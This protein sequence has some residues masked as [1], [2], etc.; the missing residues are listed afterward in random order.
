M[1]IGATPL[2]AKERSE[3]VRKYHILDTEYEKE[4]NDIVELAS[5]IANTPISVITILDE[6]RQ[7][8][9]AKK[10]LDIR[11]TN[12]D[13]AFC[14]HTAKG[15][16][17]FIVH[18]AAKDDR[19]S[20][21]PLVTG[22][23][24]IKF[25]AGLPVHMSDGKC[26]G[27]LAVIDTVS[28]DLT[29]AQK[30]GLNILRLQVTRLLELRALNYELLQHANEKSTLMMD[31]LDRVSD[32][33]IAVDK[34]WNVTYIN[35]HAGKITNREPKNIVG[36]NLWN[37][38][39]EAFTGDSSFPLMA[40]EAMA[41]Q[42]EQYNEEFF[43]PYKMWLE[44]HIYPSASG[45][46]IYFKDITFRKNAERALRESEMNYRR[47]IEGN[48]QPMWIFRMEDLRILEVNESAIQKYGYSRDEF[49]NL[50]ILDLRPSN[51]IEEVTRFI[52]DGDAINKGF[53]QSGPWKHRLRNGELIDVEIT[54]QEIKWQGKRARFTMA[55]DVTKRLKM[56]E[57]LR[58]AE[59]QYRSIF[60]NAV[61]GIYQTT[62]DGRFIA[63]NPAMAQM[64]GYAN[65]E[66]LMMMVTDIANQLYADADKR[67]EMTEL[68]EAEGKVKGLELRVFTKDGRIMWVRANIRAIKDQSQIVKYLE[69]TLEDITA[70]KEAEEKLKKQFDELQK[71]NQELDRFVYS[72]SHD[73]RA[74]LATILGLIHVAELESPSPMF[75]EYLK[76]IR[77][78]IR[79][80]DGFINDI[81]DYSL[82]A[83]KEVQMEEIN[84]HELIGE[85]LK[86]FNFIAS[87][88]RLKVTLAIKNTVP[89]RSDPYRLSIIF[90]NLLSNAV[91]YQDFN[92]TDSF[93]TIEVE[94]F[95]DKAS[96]RVADNG[97]GIH[98]KHGDKI[99]EMFYRASENSKGSG[100]GLYIARETVGKLGGRMSVDT[101][102]GEYTRF[103]V[104]IPNQ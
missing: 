48:P 51:E 20:E 22:P 16:E 72:V 57:S 4:Y 46:S 96:I 60:E 97:I 71:T 89:F 54:S 43:E 74:P 81:L 8:F 31:V 65:P 25:Y 37:E 40:H 64:F 73:L 68:L 18:D 98:Q 42:K 6:K 69:G 24:F 70:R 29:P 41:K 63:A 11:E 30:E 26:I 91:K 5:Q 38:F 76:M 101:R 78:N 12:I 55:W 21:N 1:I 3:A 9:K 35:D 62:P 36:K 75:N 99:F 104:V 13:I 84:F 28:R 86:N 87:A 94:T 79:R 102:F 85:I 34:D 45:L 10:G 88:D 52:R 77:I 44:C 93:V 83:R 15:H 53:T 49:L 23:P 58:H 33:F 56:E 47:L 80:L 27:S 7:W 92:K 2:D 103:D 14:S 100:L 59:E 39:P 90:N 67:K 17:M 66:E 61:E 32:A 95:P 19:F 82:N 50:T